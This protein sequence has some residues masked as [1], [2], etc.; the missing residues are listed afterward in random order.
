MATLLSRV[1]QQDLIDFARQI[2]SAMGVITAFE[3]RIG[4]IRHYGTG[5]APLRRIVEQELGRRILD[6]ENA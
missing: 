3:D 2:E 6:G 1:P 4:H 5:L